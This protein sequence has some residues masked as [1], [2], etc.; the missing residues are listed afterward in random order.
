MQIESEQAVAL[1]SIGRYLLLDFSRGNE[2]PK[3]DDVRLFRSEDRAL[4]EGLAVRLNDRAQGNAED[5]G[6]YPGW[7]EVLD[8]DDTN[9]FEDVAELGNE[10]DEMDAVMEEESA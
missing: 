3:G 6:G 9:L 1:M 5:W 10:L 4:L 8:L 2:T 7:A